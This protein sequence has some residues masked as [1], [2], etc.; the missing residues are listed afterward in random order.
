MALQAPV[1][2]VVA[3]LG[4][5]WLIWRRIAGRRARARPVI[6]PLVPDA[7]RVRQSTE[8]RICESRLRQIFRASRLIICV[9]SAPPACTARRRND[10]GYTGRV[11][12]ACMPALIPPA[13]A[14]LAALALGVATALPVAGQSRPP[15]EVSSPA[16]VALR[17]DA[18][19]PRRPLRR[20]PRPHRALPPDAD[21]SA[22]ARPR[23]R[24]DRAVRR[25]GDGVRG[26]HR[27]A[28]RS[29]RRSSSLA[30]CMLL[31]GRTAEARACSSRWS[32][33]RA[34]RRR[35]GAGPCGARRV[36][37]WPL[38]AG[39]HALP[40]RRRAHRRRSEL[41]VA[42]GE[43]F[44]EKQNRPEAVRSFR[45]ALQSD[46]RNAAA[47]AGLARAFADENGATARELAAR[48]LGLNPSLVPAHL[49][50]A[51]LAL[52]E[53]HR[54]EARAAI[55]Q[56]LAVNPSSLDALSRK[57]AIAMLDDRTADFDALV[58]A[59][60]AINPRYGDVYRVAGAQAA[61][62]YRFDAAASLTRKALE[63]RSGQRP[64]VGRPRR[65]PAAHG[66]RARRARRRSTRAFR[67]DPVRRRHL[68]PARA[69]RQSRVVR[70]RRGRHR[71]VP[72]APRRSAGAAR[73]RAAAGARARSTRWPRATGTRWTGRSWSRSFPKHDDFAV[74]NVGLPGMIGALGACFGRVVTLD[75]P[76]ARPPG[77]FNWQATLWHEMAHV[78][79]LQMSENR[80]PRWLTE[81][82]SVYEEQRARPEWGREMELRFAEALERGE[83]LRLA[84]LN[85]G[86]MSGE[87][88][89]LAYYEASLLVD[90]L[91][92]T[93]GEPALQALVRAFADGVSVTR[94]CGEA[95]G[96]TL[97][98]LEPRVHGVGERALRRGA[99]GARGPEDIR[100]HGA[101]AARDDRDAGGG[102]SRQLRP[103]A[104][105]RRRARRG[106]RS[107][108][109]V[110]RR[111]S[112]PRPVAAAASATT[113]RWRGSRS[114]RS[115]PGDS[116]ARHRGARTP[117]R[118]RRR[119]HRSGAPAGRA[120]RSA[121]RSRRAPR[122]RGRASPSSIPFDATASA[123][124]GRQALDTSAPEE[125]ARWFRAALAAG[126]VDKAAAHC[127]LA[128]SYLAVG[129]GA[130]GQ[131]PG[132]RGARGRADVRP[133]AGPAA[134]DRGRGALMRAPAAGWRCAGVLVAALAA[135]VPSAAPPRGGPGAARRAPGRP[136]VDVRPHQI[137]RAIRPGS[138][139]RFDYWGEP[140]AID[141]PAA[142]QNLSRR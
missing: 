10:A 3:T 98:E 97:A 6:P 126:P 93:R 4:F 138:N 112:A 34:L 65:A 42:W 142:E 1:A 123:A 111:G 66:R 79:T 110:R 87:T 128:E 134:R 141:A 86:F 75:S 12:S 72:P 118:A 59:V 43:L 120:A 113:A 116:D 27:A 137:H 69:A 11:G 95:L 37:A 52:D 77:T 122:G 28:R 18:R 89:A 96:P 44:L 45:A 81:G 7:D 132:A 85:R 22:A 70:D 109:R 54:D 71:D 48:A 78:V 105:A 102:I 33:R 106:G 74:R 19:P 100:P 25:G 17:G 136:A 125:A 23:A 5:G 130:A 104:A 119:Q 94:R 36:A 31:R 64:R 46:R 92:T 51:D 127:D 56:A 139:Y 13:A 47:F 58:A 131:A 124:L 61:R 50:L 90:H 73:A 99:R 62:H 41:Q 49:V 9:A 68:Q 2:G 121:R 29:A 115:Q 76:R 40:R 80:I 57:A 84:E 55:E 101:D 15:D 8:T 114:W 53:D 21:V 14:V 60:L 38:R 82:I 129:A 67:A 117:A 26:Q 108:G 63:T 103:A 135:A 35:R 16:R 91:V 107:A 140:W 83:V 133:R 88:I 39:Q 30:S 24:R 20:R 32:P